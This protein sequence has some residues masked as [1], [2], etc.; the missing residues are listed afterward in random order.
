MCLF[1]DFE[2]PPPT[3]FRSLGPLRWNPNDLCRNLNR[4]LQGTLL[5]I[6]IITPMLG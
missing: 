6:L 5:G 2:M 4:T 3:L 1:I